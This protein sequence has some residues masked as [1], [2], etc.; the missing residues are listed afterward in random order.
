VTSFLSTLE[1][2]WA[3][4]F[5]R[6]WSEVTGVAEPFLKQGTDLQATEEGLWGL[7]SPLGQILELY[8]LRNNNGKSR[9]CAFV[10]YAT[11]H[12]AEVAITQLNG[13]GMPSGKT[14][15]VKFADRASATKPLATGLLNMYMQH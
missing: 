14:L 11:K 5:P 3:N 8:V 9:G 15:V 4:L 7:F 1:G 13:R 6:Q 10:T 12:L 2:L